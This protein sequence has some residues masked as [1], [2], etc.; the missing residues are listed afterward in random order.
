MFLSERD[1]DITF[2][3]D[4]YDDYDSRGDDDNIDGCGCYT[5]LISI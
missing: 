3:Y 1:L 5:N 4:D 2:T